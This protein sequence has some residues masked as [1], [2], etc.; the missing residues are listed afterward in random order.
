MHLTMTT[1]GF[2]WCA[3]AYVGQIPGSRLPSLLLMELQVA[4]QP[5]NRST[6]GFKCATVWVAWPTPR[7]RGIGDRWLL[8][9]LSSDR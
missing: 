5:L 4:A 2:A 1:V 8:G 6:F 3:S 9:R 7:E